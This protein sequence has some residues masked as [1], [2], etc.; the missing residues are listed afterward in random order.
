MTQTTPDTRPTIWIDADACPVKAEIIK[1]GLRHKNPMV[2]VS[3]QWIRLDQH[4]L[5]RLEVVTG[6][7]DAADDYIVDHLG[8]QDLVITA[9]IPLADRSLKKG[10]EVLGP[11][12]KAFT[13][14]GIGMAMAMR[15]LK[16]TLRDTGEISGFNKPFDKK[17]RS[18]FLQAMEDVMRRING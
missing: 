8:D 7:F 17:D 9:D 14:D 10:A 4:P 18:Q 12:G 1:V 13:T 3:N 2:F 5:I 15:D 11:T 16:A 6:K